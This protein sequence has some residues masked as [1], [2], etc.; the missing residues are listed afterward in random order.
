MTLYYII[1]PVYVYCAICAARMAYRSDIRRASLNYKLLSGG[2]RLPVGVDLRL[3]AS[4][5]RTRCS[6]TKSGHCQK[7][8]RSDRR[9][10]NIVLGIQY[11]N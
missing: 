7:A 6:H 10:Y 1:W 5:L 4:G 8:L 11:Y 9:V 3:R 2:G